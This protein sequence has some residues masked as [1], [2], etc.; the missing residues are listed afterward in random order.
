[1]PPRPA[2]TDG[3]DW[4]Y[5][6]VIEDRYKRM[7]VNMSASLL[8]HQIQS[9]AVVLKL[10]WLCIPVYISEGNPNQF[11]WAL[12]ALL[13]VGNVCFYLGKP[14]GRCVLPLMKVAASCV[15]ITVSLTFI[16]FWKMYV[17]EPKTSLY[18]RRL[19]K[20]LKD[21]GRA[22]SPTTLEVL[23][24]VEG[25]V[26]VFVLAGC[27]VCFFVL[28]NWVKDAMELVKEREQRN[29]A[30]AGSAAAAPKKKR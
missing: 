27:G 16:S 18:S 19:Y 12:L 24:T 22:S 6:E 9:L 14:R 11:L 8:L 26:D 2:G 7:A 28:N 23:K 29:K 30:A 5:R 15:L 4:S 3:S 25:L 17:M 10:A 20:F 13:V 1:M 21:Q